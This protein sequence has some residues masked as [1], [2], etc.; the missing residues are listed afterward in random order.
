M[1]M[2][3]AIA[4]LRIRAASIIQRWWRGH[5]ARCRFRDLLWQQYEAEDQAM[6]LRL[7]TACLV[8]GQHESHAQR[9][10]RHIAQAVGRAR[11]AR[12]ACVIQ[13]A[14]RHYCARRAQLRIPRWSAMQHESAAVVLA[15]D[16]TFVNGGGMGVY[17]SVN[18]FV[19]VPQ[20]R[21]CQDLADIFA[22]LHW[23]VCV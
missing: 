9:E 16:H 7:D 4:I 15:T 14:W 19:D 23:H 13:R 11:R 2:D 17:R 12:A 20:V 21:V 6:Q 1:S 3:P 10:R 5:A 8:L 18:L 22:C